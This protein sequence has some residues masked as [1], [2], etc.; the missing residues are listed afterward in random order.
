MLWKKDLKN[1]YENTN[2]NSVFS[3]EIDK[4]VVEV[5]MNSN[6]FNEDINKITY[7]SII[8]DKKQIE[9]L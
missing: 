2:S 5:T 3:L 8:H 4:E 6:I 9:D 1:C 7:D